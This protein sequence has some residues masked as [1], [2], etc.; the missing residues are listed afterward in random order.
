MVKYATQTISFLFHPAIIGFLTISLVARQF[1]FGE[2][3]KYLAPITVLVVGI[4]AS[5][6]LFSS[7]EGSGWS[8]LSPT[9]RQ[10]L[11]VALILGTSLSAITYNTIL[12][13]K[14]LGFM[15]M[16]ISILWAL[17]YLSG[18]FIAHASLHAGIFVWG[19]LTLAHFVNLNFSFG[20]LM[21]PILYWSKISTKE[22]NWLELMLGTV[23]GAV[24]G[25]L[26]WTF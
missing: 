5:Y 18:R 8:H 4:V 21:L 13:S 17:Y 22:H 15:A 12:P 1:Y 25:L 20:L 9:I 3:L 24:A 7:K 26:L 10:N 19:L 16:G 6:L 23:I 11:F 14:L 2:S